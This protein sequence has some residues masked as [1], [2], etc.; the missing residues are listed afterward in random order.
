VQAPP[1]SPPPPIKPPPVQLSAE[2]LA[3]AADLKAKRGIDAL[4]VRV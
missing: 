3:A 1:P 4:K 2:E